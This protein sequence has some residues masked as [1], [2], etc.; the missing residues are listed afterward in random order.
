MRT[1]KLVEM[2]KE[3][4]RNNL[5]ESHRQR[6]KKTKTHLSMVGRYGAGVKLAQEAIK[7]KI[8]VKTDT[9]GEQI[10]DMDPEVNS[11]QQQR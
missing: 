7:D 8:V 5:A 1:S 11:V 6:Y 2:I 10:I 3:I 4:A 9:G